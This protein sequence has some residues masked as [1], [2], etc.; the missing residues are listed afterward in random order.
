MKRSLLAFTLV[1]ALCGMLALAACQS[2]G[3]DSVDAT[4]TRMTNFKTQVQALKG[5]VSSNAAALNDVVA[6]ADSDPKPAFGK[7]KSDTDALNDSYTRVQSRLA[8][9]QSQ[10]STMFADWTKRSLEITDPELRKASED[11]RADLKK[12]LDGVVSAMRTAIDDLRGYTASSKDLVTY[13]SQ[14]LTPPSIKAIGS[15][16]KS[17]AKDAESINKKL[18]DVV[19]SAEKASSD[20]ATAKPPPPK[21]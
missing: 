4:S 10:A 20:F 5:Q 6:K 14:D 15:K 11:R 9:V 12:T 7:F 18:D 21:S 17:H 1:P 13:L 3:N 19:S 8:D 2:A 16:A